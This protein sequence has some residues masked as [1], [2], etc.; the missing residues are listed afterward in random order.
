MAL[1]WSATTSVED[2]L[3]R[4]VAWMAERPERVPWYA[5]AIAAGPPAK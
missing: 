3:R 1:G 4:T 2:G 5:S